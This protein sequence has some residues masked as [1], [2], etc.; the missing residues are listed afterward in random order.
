MLR[1]CTAVLMVSLASTV[2]LASEGDDQARSFA[3]IYASLCLKNFQ[4]LEALREKLARL[5]KLP[6]EKAALFL[7]GRKG[8]SWPVP[9]KHGE[10]VLTLTAGQNFCAVHA[11]KANTEEATKL[12]SGLVANAPSPFT[13]KVVKDEQTHSS[14]SG[15]LRSLSYEWST[16]GISRKILFTLTT[17]SSESAQLQVLGFAAIIAP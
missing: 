8:D 5:P 11:R 4:D 14:A 2:C 6:P 12:F 1:F 13:A 3:R 9:D 15:Q 16:P 7:S 10:F 17:A